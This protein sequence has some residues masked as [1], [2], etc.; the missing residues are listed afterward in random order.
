MKNL[1]LFFL[2]LLASAC[3]TSK[4][5]IGS[6]DACRSLV[7][8]NENNKAIECYTKEINT[9]PEL[10]Q[11]YID[12][13]TAYRNVLDYDKALSDFNHA[14]MLDPKSHKGYVG[15]G[16]VYYRQQNYYLA[17][18]DFSQ[19]I[20]LYP[21]Q[22]G[23][24]YLLGMAYYQDKKYSSAHIEFTE[25]IRLDPSR[26]DAYLYRGFV[27]G[28]THDIEGTIADFTQ[29]IKL[30]IKGQD[31]IDALVMRGAAYFDKGDFD[32][33]LLDFSEVIKL[34]PDNPI[35]KK[36]LDEL[37]SKPEKRLQ[38]KTP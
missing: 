31:A 11:A 7:D 22:A 20:G 1:F 26:A 27:N 32:L 12:R 6:L 35:A 10:A 24:Y 14:I 30:G 13:G 17:V 23:L 16:N 3:A 33:A 5:S 19:A 36:G 28:C 21:K 37:K 25:A 8:K 29:A 9:N 34:D 18:N 2:V 4:D 38:R 15:R